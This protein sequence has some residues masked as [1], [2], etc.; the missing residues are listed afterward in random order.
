M[1]VFRNSRYSPE[2]ADTAMATGIDLDDA[3]AQF[4]TIEDCIG[5]SITV[6]APEWTSSETIERIEGAV[7]RLSARG[8]IVRPGS[9][10]AGFVRRSA[11]WTAVDVDAGAQRLRSVRMPAPLVGAQRLLAVNDVR[12]LT[13]ARP[14][15]ALGLWAL[16]AHPVIRMGARF[17]G[18][19]DGLTAEIALAVHP[20]RYVVVESDRA[21]GFTSVLVT[22]DPIVAD[23]L[24]LGLRQTRARVRGAG[25]W[26]DPLVQ[27]ATELQ[28]GARN[29]SEIRV[30]AI[31]SSALSSEQR[32]HATARM[33]E[34][35][36]LIGVAHGN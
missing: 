14:V 34:A 36:E 12:G 23:L 32:A 28:L 6:A 19:R 17:A 31:V 24:V 30:D 21:A 5:C 20:D 18:A 27:A 8:P 4:G 7:S 15:V 25:P 11:H 9:G 2:P 26:E 22:P 13:G 16:F 35:A 1:I 10:A 33:V 29:A 3:L